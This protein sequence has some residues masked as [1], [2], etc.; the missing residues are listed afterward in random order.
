[1][2]DVRAW[3]EERTARA[4]LVHL[5]PLW[6]EP[7]SRLVRE[8][9]DLGYRVVVVSADLERGRA[10]WVGRE[11]TRDLIEEV[12]AHGADPCGEHG[13]FHTFVFDGPELRRPLSVERGEVVE[14]EGHRL[15][16]LILAPDEPGP[17]R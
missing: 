7:P 5:E 9:V 14:M 2:A 10:D 8:V 11:L 13:E 17:I 3:Y 4:G 1:L 15:I 12:E 6:G 16:D